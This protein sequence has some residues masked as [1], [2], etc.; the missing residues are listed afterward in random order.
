MESGGQIDVVYADL[1]KAFDKVPRK[2]LISKLCSYKFNPEVIKWIESFLVNRGHMIRINSFF[3]FWREVLSG[4][5]QGS[6]LGP[7]LF[8]FCLMIWLITVIIDLTYFCTLTVKRFSDITC[9]N[10]GD[11]LQ[12]DLPNVDGKVVI[13]I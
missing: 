6:T 2:R 10:D 4:I 7:L 13:K 11:L 3:S 8:K 12:K 5:P 9:N 1:E